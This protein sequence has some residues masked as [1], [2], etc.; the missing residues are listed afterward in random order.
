MYN[1]LKVNCF[2][3]IRRKE[4]LAVTVDQ[5]GRFIII[6]K[7]HNVMSRSQRDRVLWDNILLIMP[8]HDPRNATVSKTL[9]TIQTKALALNSTPKGSVPKDRYGI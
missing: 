4:A 8:L 7:P 5:S 3:W 1:S 9:C 6:S 2:S